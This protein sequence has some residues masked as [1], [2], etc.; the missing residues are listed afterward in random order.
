MNDTQKEYQD[1]E[2]VSFNLPASTESHLG[3]VTVKL[4][5][6][7]IVRYKIVA[8]RQG[9][10]L[11]A[12]CASLKIKD[13][14]EERWIPSF[15]LDSHSENDRLMRFVKEI[16]AKYVKLDSVDSNAFVDVNG[17]IV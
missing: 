3:V 12:S 7:I 4:F 1:F 9:R 17:V 14:F 13:D 8:V 5:D 15:F 16:A 2:F 10:V 11:F 6:R